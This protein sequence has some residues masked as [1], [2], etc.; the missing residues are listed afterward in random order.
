VPKEVKIKCL[1]FSLQI[2]KMMFYFISYKSD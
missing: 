2:G 1:Q